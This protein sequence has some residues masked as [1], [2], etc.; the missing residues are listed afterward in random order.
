ML[1]TPK[2]RGPFDRA[3]IDMEAIDMEAILGGR[4]MRRNRRADWSRRLVAENRLSIDDLIWPIFLIEGERQRVPV[5]S[6]PDVFRFSVDEAV[7]EV[8]KAAAYG[9][10]AVALF[11]YTDPALRDPEGSESLNPD[12]LVC[13]AAR[14][15]KAAVPQIG[16]VCDVALDPYT[17]HGHDGLMEGERILNDETVAQLV[18]QALVQAEAGADVIAPSDMMDGRIGAI[19]AAL[20][21]SGFGDVQIMAY[22]AKYASAF[23]GP[24]RDAIGT[25]KTLVGDKR[26]YQMDPA[27]SDEALREVE[28][29]LA[30]GADMVMVKPG[31]PYLDIVRRVKDR[32]AVPTFAYQ[33][34]GEYAMI[35]GAAERGWIDG[36]RAM[37]ESLVA[38]KRAGADGVL[39]YFA[40]AVA[41]LL[42]GR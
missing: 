3:A 30:E 25:S 35:R 24:F 5:A 22:A 16:I 37:L 8:E 6:M 33:V 20:D 10:P 32:F 36:E 12:N 27:N 17:S 29:D 4:R 38:F 18:G 23:Y 34:S 14:A 11:P 19:R 21:R 15:I 1:E 39:T 7:R 28:L 31:M 9:I 42:S 13:R 41:A 2:K 26:T 40:P